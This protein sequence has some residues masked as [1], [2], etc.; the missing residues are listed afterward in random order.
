MQ[1]QYNRPY[2][3][4]YQRVIVSS[5]SRYQVIE[6][7][8]KIGKTI[9]ALVWL[10][11]QALSGKPGQHFWWTAPSYKQTDIAFNRLQRFISTPQMFKVNHTNHSI[12]LPNGAIMEFKTTED[13]NHLYGEDVS[14]CVMDE[15]TRMKADA[16]HAIRSTLTATQGRCIIIGNIVGINNWGYKLAREVEAG[17]EGWSYMKLTAED[18]IRAGILKKEEIED[19][20][21]SLPKGKFMELYY[22]IPDE[23]S[24]NKFCYSFR[25]NDHIGNIKVNHDYPIVLSF[26]FNVNPI[27]CGVYQHYDGS[28]YCTELIK[29]ENSNIHT[30][31]NVLS[32]KF[33]NSLLLVTGDASGK[34]RTAITEDTTNYYEIIKNK[35]N[36]N[37]SQFKVPAA[38]PSIEKNQV[39]VNAVFENYN[40]TFDAERAAALI[41]DC[42]FVQVDINGKIIKTDRNDPTQQADALDTFRYYLNAFHHNLIKIPEYA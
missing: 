1:I 23:T 21:K 14:A 40:V 20:R 12:T 42:K 3:T 34:S 33:N 32:Q 27:C 30:L 13:A 41:F 22:G 8:T 25:D 10:F 36:L 2:L 17:K 39:L 24:S 6:A 37:R 16:W 35:L 31:C 18:A 9:A 11:E 26:D 5:E 7:S 19:A 28:I 4:D 38:N 15:F 29:L